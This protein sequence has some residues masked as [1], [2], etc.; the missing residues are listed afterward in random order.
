MST[1]VTPGNIPCSARA[2]ASEAHRAG[3]AGEIR[4]WAASIAVF[5]YFGRTDRMEAAVL[6]NIPIS[7]GKEKEQNEIQA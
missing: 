1:S 5:T 3:P 7:P 6:A 2:G 4:A